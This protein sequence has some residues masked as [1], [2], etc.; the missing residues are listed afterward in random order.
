MRENPVEVIQEKLGGKNL[1]A[2]VVQLLGFR[3]NKLLSTRVNSLEEFTVL[4]YTASGVPRGGGFGGLTPLPKFR[5]FAKAEPNSQ[6][7][8]KYIQN[9]LIRMCFTHLKNWVEPLT[10]GLPPDPWSLCPLSST[11]FVEP[12]RPY[13]RKNSLVRHCAQL[14]AVLHKSLKTLCW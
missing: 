4:L 2:I 1:C 10:M 13:P 5:S 3:L 12:P 7:R 14:R 11:E 9:N 8:E 6:F